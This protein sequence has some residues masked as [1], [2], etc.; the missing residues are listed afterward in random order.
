MKKFRFKYAP[1][2][3]VLLI[4]VLLFSVGGLIWNIFN[5]VELYSFKKTINIISYAIIILI[6]FALTIFV[7]SVIF[8][9]NYVIKGDFLYVYFGFLRPNTKQKISFAYLSLRKAISWW[10]T[11]RSK[12]TRLS[13]QTRVF[14]MILC[15]LLE[16][17]TNKSYTTPRLTA[18]IQQINLKFCLYKLFI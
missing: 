8:Y 5:L 6:T 16:K 10:H 7:L 9:G 12:L 1:S 18:K 17:L 3:W 2:V 14:T 15:F 4:A 11:L 13:L